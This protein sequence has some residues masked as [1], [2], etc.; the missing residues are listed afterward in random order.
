MSDAVL[1]KVYQGF[2]F[3]ER[4]EILGSALAPS[5]IRGEA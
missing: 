4:A 1:L 3:C 2:K 5:V